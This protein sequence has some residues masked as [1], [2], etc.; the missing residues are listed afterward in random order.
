MLA[1]GGVAARSQSAK[2]MPVS[3]RALPV[4][5]RPLPFAIG[6]TL[7]YEAKLSKIISGVTVGDLT[8][9]VEDS[10]NPGELAITAE[11]RS[12]GTLLK[13]AHYSFL[14]QFASKI[15]EKRFRIEQTDRKTTEKERVR[16]G[17]AEFD[18]TDKRVTYVETDPKEP[19]RPPR[20][21]A[22]DIEDQTHDVV[23]GIYALRMMPLAVGKKFDLTVSDSGLVYDVP[24]RVTAR[25]LQKTMFGQVWCFRVEPDVF[26]PGKMIEDKGQMSIWITDDSRHI[27]V[28]SRIDTDFGRVE[29]RLRSAEGIKSPGAK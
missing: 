17:K 28:R 16:T 11:A 25:E 2:P 20:K 27:P 12:K 21:I 5:D 6:E 29:I 13:I 9:K 4:S 3:D 1:V 15:D 18:Y 10:K 19:M 8:F 14:Y 22:S 26:G 7:V 24:V 23:S